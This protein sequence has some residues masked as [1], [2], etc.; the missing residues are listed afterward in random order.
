M[1]SILDVRPELLR[2]SSTL[3]LSDEMNA[4]SIPEKKAEN[5]RTMVISMMMIVIVIV[6]W[7]G[8]RA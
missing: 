1:F 8:R 6:V 7:W 2:S 5:I 4:I 3:S